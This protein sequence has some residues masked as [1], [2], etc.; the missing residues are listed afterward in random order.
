[1]TIF[2]SRVQFFNT[3]ILT[4][5]ANCLVC[6]YINS[7][8]FIQVAFQKEGGIATQVFSISYVYALSTAAEL[9]FN[10]AFYLRLFM[11]WYI[12]RESNSKNSLMTQ[13]EANGWFEGFPILLYTKYSYCILGMWYTALYGPLVPELF[14]FSLVGFTIVYWVEKVPL[15]Y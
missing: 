13:S 5:V 14:F 10:P 7:N 3:A 1:M 4:L 15:I 6:Y 12:K 2:L 11:R 9:I 8:A